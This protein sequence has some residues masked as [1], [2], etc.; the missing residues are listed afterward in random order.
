MKFNV[1]ELESMICGTLAD[2]LNIEI[3][4]ARDGGGTLTEFLSI[5]IDTHTR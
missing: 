5:E 2:I 1:N 4:F 3:D